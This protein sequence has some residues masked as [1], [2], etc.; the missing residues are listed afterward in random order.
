[1]NMRVFQATTVL[2]PRLAGVEPRGRDR[3]TKADKE[4]NRVLRRNVKLVV[5]QAAALEGSKSL[6]YKM[7]LRASTDHRICL[8]PRRIIGNPQIVFP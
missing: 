8:F 6:E 1:M 2:K 5:K 3:P 7:K 4:L